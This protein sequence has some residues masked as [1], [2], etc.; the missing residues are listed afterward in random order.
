MN[1]QFNEY[2]LGEILEREGMN[3]YI[4]RY[5]NVL[6]FL[7]MSLVFLSFDSGSVTVGSFVSLVPTPVGF[8]TFFITLFF[9]ACNDVLKLF[10]NALKNMKRKHKRIE[11]LES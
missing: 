3:K 6:K 11:L 9:I 7:C 4:C 2:L 10:L 5:V 8:I 1:L